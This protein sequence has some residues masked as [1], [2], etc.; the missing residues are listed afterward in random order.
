MS[1]NILSDGNA[2]WAFPFFDTFVQRAFPLVHIVHD[3]HE[4]PNLVIKSHWQNERTYTC[5]Y[6]CVSG[7]SY[8]VKHKSDQEPFL[9]IN[10][11]FSNRPNS[12]YVPYLVF[13]HTT[14]QRPGHI[15]NQIPKQYCCAYVNSNRVPIREQLFQSLRRLEP[16]CY[17][18]G[19]SLRT[20]DNPF[21]LP[22]GMDERA[23]NNT[24]FH[25]FGMYVAMENT[26]V[27]GYITEKIGFAYNSGTVP[28]YWGDTETVNRFFNPD[29]FL[30]VKSYPSV[31]SAT[32]SIVEIWRDPHKYRTYIDA[33]ITT[34]T[35]LLEYQLWKTHY[36]TW[37][38]PIL[39]ALYEEFPDVA[40]G[41]SCFDTTCSTEEHS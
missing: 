34:H 22:D 39:E 18:F 29:S 37:Q 40:T 31:E 1:F 2:S 13:E 5:P 28:V 33:P 25:E 21:Q 10:T 38:K 7:E 4:P 14:I 8:L 3:P 20:D 23:S 19:K 12:V 41:P 35:E 6:I 24:A 27:R 16:T 30:N 15:R 9:E 11:I 36:T 32:Q 17:A 26:S